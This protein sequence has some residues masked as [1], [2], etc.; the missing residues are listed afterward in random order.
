[1]ADQ[2]YRVKAILEA[3]DSSFSSTFKRALSSV[4][5]L[6][7]SQGKVGSS[8]KNMIGGS[9]VFGAVQKG[10]GMIASSMDSAISRF[11]TL[12][13]FPIMM[14]NLGYSADDAS[15]SI[16][17][18]S[19]G[20]DGLPTAL[21]D[22]AGSVT[23]IAPL[24]GSLDKA[25]DITLAMNN[26]L[27]A[28]GKSM[29][30]QAN[31][32][33]QYSQMLSYGKVDMQSWKSMMN[34]MPGQL[35]QLSHKL[36]GANKN[37]MDLYDAMK[38][39]TVTFDQFN[40]ALLDLNENGMDGFASFQDQAVSAT[41]GIGTAVKNINTAI[42]KGLTDTL[43]TVSDSME[44]A[45]F[46]TI[47]DNLNKVK[48]AIKSVFKGF[49]SVLGNVLPS[50]IKGLIS[51][52]NKFK[53]V[54]TTIRR[55]LSLTARSFHNLGGSL[56]TA[57][58]TAFKDADISGLVSGLQS[59]VRT[60]GKIIRSLAD[61]A[62]THADT[63]AKFATVLPKIVAGFVAFKLAQK[64]VSPILAFASA[65]KKLKGAKDIGK[66]LTGA[67]NGMRKVNDASGSFLKV[68]SS[69]LM[70]AVAFGVLAQA[71]TAVAQTKGATA[72]LIGMGVAFGILSLGIS[73]LVEGMGFFKPAK[74]AQ[75]GNTFLKIGA[76]VFLVAAGFSLLALSATYLASQGGLAI[77]VFVGMAVVIGALLAV[78][79]VFGAGLTAAAGGLLAFGAAMLMCGAG[80]LIASVG[81]AIVAGVLPTLAQYGLQGAVAILA[82]GGAML[83]LG[84]GAIVAGAG[85]LVLTA[86]LLGLTAGLL[87]VTVGVVAF[88]AAMIAAS[89]GVAVFAGVMALIQATV[90][91]IAKSAKSAGKSI[92]EMVTGVG[93]VKTG[94]GSIG[95]LATGTANTIKGAFQGLQASLPSI[96]QS[97]VS[98]MNSALSSGF[99]MAQANASSAASAIVSRLMSASSGA[100]SAGMMIG[101][102]LANGMASQLGRVQAIAASL[103]A[104]A[105][106][107][108]AAKAKIGSPSKVTTYFGKM[109]GQGFI[110]GMKNMRSG[111]QKTASKTFAVAQPNNSYKMPQTDRDAF[112]GVDPEITTIL[113]IDGRK[114]AKATSRNIRN[115]NYV[116]Q[117]RDNRK[118]GVV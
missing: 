67:S 71:S 77:G 65:F 36:L 70:I 1:M 23:K 110:N 57:F 80:A 101:A 31:A 44:K 48:G 114:F 40:D 45:G 92:T 83:V 117:R 105:N 74:L 79:S 81:I 68:A 17:K 25:T 5:S 109:E 90:K 20:I 16:Q 27:L 99:S 19:D 7:S 4:Q 89:A 51:F 29:D 97:A 86:G 24:T 58:K 2:Q 73:K 28:G 60:V 69:I 66:S 55:E 54:L 33:E 61:F 18:M 34:A 75:I 47:A 21:D 3:Q 37:G 107:A 50:A 38:E 94:L 108:I 106:R 39:G 49:N 116:E 87:G 32:L 64:A 85:L 56:K 8:L 52:G 113:A 30:A 9:F 13:N 35:N 43:Q 115:Q 15:A 78:V 112:Y 95:S 11:D 82:L 14:R 22:I 62:S 111:I 53:P 72:V 103:A 76:S 100:Y 93:V 10:M 88:S 104:A 42:T 41:Q 26:A 12:N 96:A 46:G 59:F 118:G 6:S 63:I 102:G 91:G 98:G 84:A